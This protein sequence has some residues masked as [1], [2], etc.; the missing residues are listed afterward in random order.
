[1]YRIII[2]SVKKEFFVLMQI[3]SS[4]NYAVHSCKPCPLAPDPISVFSHVFV[5]FAKPIEIVYW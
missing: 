4:S 5:V 2:L 3:A 1:M